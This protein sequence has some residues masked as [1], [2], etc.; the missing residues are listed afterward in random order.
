[1]SLGYMAS[2]K[3]IAFIT[4]MIK[5]SSLFRDS[6]YDGFFQSFVNKTPF[7]ILTIDVGLL[8]NFYLRQY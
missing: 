2:L 7:F 1:V 6:N 8:T 4:K 3:T 5:L